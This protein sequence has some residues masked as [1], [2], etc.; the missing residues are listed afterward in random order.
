MSNV[1]MD[2]LLSMSRGASK[3]QRE[4]T[5]QREL[6]AQ[7][8][9]S[10]ALSS[11]A[12]EDAMSAV[13]RK[14][15]AHTAAVMAPGDDA[16]SP[17]LHSSTA[18]GQCATISAP[19][20]HAQM[21][22]ELEQFLTPN[23]TGAPLHVLD[24]GSGSGYLTACIA[25]ML[26]AKSD[27]GSADG[28][29]SS[30]AASVVVALEHS[31]VLLEQSQANMTQDPH[32]HPLVE[33]QE[34]TVK[35]R[36][37]HGSA[38]DASLAWWP[39]SEP[40]FDL[41]HCGAA[42]AA[43]PEHLLPLL[44]VGGRMLVPVAS[45]GLPAASSSSPVVATAT[46]APG[47]VQGQAGPAQQ[48]L[49][50]ELLERDAEGNQRYKASIVHSCSLAPMKDTASAADVDSL[51]HVHAEVASLRAEVQRITD[52]VTAW[53]AAFKAQHERKPSAG[54]MMA[55]AHVG[56]LL[57]RSA[58]LKKRLAGLEK[59]AARDRTLTAAAKQ[60]TA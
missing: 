40:R 49:L 20:A 22:Q 46:A 17:Y 8:K 47:S 9:D 38:L 32:T 36:F 21:L 60:Q 30:S 11:E 6:V 42:F 16:P 19:H 3:Q 13:D 39:A 37:I 29:A 14:H 43:L 10:G 57:K 7:L 25:H 58:P 55:D 53:Q 51:T 18:I 31:A 54:E 41:I 26:A 23:A 4:A 45:T 50:V 12:V 24:V 33:G 56:A 59:L 52:E 5:T 2:M 28:A 27:A 15:Y 34:A 48:L 44:R 1:S 35:L